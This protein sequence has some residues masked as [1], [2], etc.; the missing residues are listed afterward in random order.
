[1]SSDLPERVR[2]RADLET[3]LARATNYEELKPRSP[4]RPVFKLER[5]ADLLA[6]VD[7]PHLGPFDVVHVAGS[8][9]KG[10]V[11]RMLDAVLRHA[12]RGPVGLYTSPHLEDLSE[13]VQVDGRPATGA[14][15]SILVNCPER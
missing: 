15:F 6:S 13:R 10:T 1:M 2:T 5:V 11:A 4:E 14:P 3:L 8:K 7:D 12:G 9:G